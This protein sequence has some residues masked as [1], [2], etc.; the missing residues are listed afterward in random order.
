KASVTSL[1]SD[2]AERGLVQEGQVE[3]LGTVGRPGTEVRLSPQHVAGVGVELNVDY[4]AVC[5][6]DL[7][8]QVRFTSSVPMPYVAGP[9]G[10]EA[11]G[12]GVAGPRSPRPARSTTTAPWC[13]SPRTWA[14]PTYPWGRSS[15]A[16]SAWIIP[17]AR[18]RTTRSS[19]RSRRRRAW[20]G[21]ASWTS[22]TSPATRAWGRASS[23]GG[24]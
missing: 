3:R 6:R 16:A 24:A 17:S 1:V 14:G 12:L 11:E 20:P 5:L 19:P 10:S 2:L 7:A 18:S 23:P 15:P 4:I 9:E 13:A 22:S 8:G 21:A